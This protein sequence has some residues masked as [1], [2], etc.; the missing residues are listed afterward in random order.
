M[1]QGL[2]TSKP[3]RS[4]AALVALV[5]G[6]IVVVAGAIYVGQLVTG[7]PSATPVPSGAVASVSGSPRSTSNAATPA[8]GVGGSTAAASLPTDQTPGADQTPGGGSPAPSATTAGQHF[9]GGLLIADEGNNR[10]VVVND[11]GAIIWQ[12]PVAGS[13]PPGETFS[14]DDAFISP[15]HKTI[16]ANEEGN[17]VIVR[18]DIA[19]EKVIWE[20]GTFGK[21][22]GGPG[23]LWNPDDAY[24]LAN[25]DITVA[26]IKNCRILEIAPDKQIVKQWGRTG[27]CVDNAPQTYGQPN[28]DTPL[29]D[30]GMLVTEIYGARLVRLSKD[31]KVLFDIHVPLHYPSDAQ[32]LPDGNVLVVDYFTPG[33]L[34]VIN[35][36]SGKVV[37]RYAPVSGKG[38]LNH[39]SLALPLPDGTFV[40]ND[41]RR[42]RVVVIDPTSN[43]IVWTYG[44]TG[45]ASGADGYLNNPDGV[46]VAPPG[47]FN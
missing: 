12:F 31:G 32:L 27:V 36:K 25:G 19:T 43:S 30:G 29:P 21:S 24:P 28:G 35:P 34:I 15:D 44:H 1:T 20:Y 23:Q 16:V 13:L 26:D 40:L 33:S 39:P 37:Y 42:H 6:L 9:P 18:I 41:D 45:K 17:Q 47:T 14:A 11:S 5:V 8:A 3:A 2:P 4:P 7:H 22:G 46:D 10:L 38:K